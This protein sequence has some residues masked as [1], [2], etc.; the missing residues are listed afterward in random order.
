MSVHK[1][2]L[3]RAFAAVVMVTAGAT[4]CG[5]D[6]ESGGMPW[7]VKS[8]VS[9]SVALPTPSLP[10]VIPEPGGK[11]AP[12]ATRSAVSTPPVAPTRPATVAP[13]STGGGPSASEQPAVYDSAITDRSPFT[14]EAF[15]G[16]MGPR[17]IQGNK[18]TLVASDSIGCMPG[19]EPRL[20]SVTF[21]QG[22]KGIVRASFVDQAVK[23]A[24]TVAVMSLPDKATVD[25]V[26]AKLKASTDN[27]RYVT[28]LQPPAS[29]GVRI[30]DPPKGSIGKYMKI[31]HYLLLVEVAKADGTPVPDQDA[32]AN[33]VASNTLGAAVEHLNVLLWSAP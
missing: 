12:P 33:Q 15:F 22:C 24:S 25:R 7:E 10:S 6:N 11:S 17:S 21:D 1:R 26:D 29:T 32:E 23:Y 13:T 28:F 27:G 18:Y 19:A 2:A 20:E 31:G 9:T 14:P 30:A 4:A 16:A 8:P 3:I 5:E